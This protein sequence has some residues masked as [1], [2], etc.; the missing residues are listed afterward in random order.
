MLRG[1]RRRAVAAV[2]ADVDPRV[3]LRPRPARA[4]AGAAA[5]LGDRGRS[6]ARRCWISRAREAE[7]RG[8]RAH[9]V[10]VPNRPAVR[11]RPRDSTSSSAITCC[12]GCA[13]GDAMAL[14]G[15]LS[16]LI[17]PGG[18]GVFQWPY[19][20]ADPPRSSGVALGCASTC[21]AANAIANRLR[22]KASRSSRSFRPTCCRSTA[23]LR[24]FDGRRT[25]GPTHVALEHH[26]RPRLRDRCSPR[27]APSRVQFAR[28]PRRL[29]RSAR[30]R[31]RG[32]T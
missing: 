29:Q 14:L 22:G 16:A 11:E 19:R 6:I 27:R 7:R 25:S 15:R 12:S 26:E 3:R 4:A 28:E 17:A 20:A 30:H 23:M 10:R 1:H 2:R 32:A 9:R 31:V 5:G 21:P 24:A 8:A 13:R 18:V